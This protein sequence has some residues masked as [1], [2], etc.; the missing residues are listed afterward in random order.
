MS[1]ATVK[2]DTELEIRIDALQSTSKALTGIVANIKEWSFNEKA[3]GENDY[4]ITAVHTA[5]FSFSTSDVY[6]VYY[7][8]NPIA[9]VCREY[10]QTDDKTFG[11]KAIVVYPVLDNEQTDLTKGAVLQLPDKAALIHGGSVCW[12]TQNSSLNYTAGHSKPIEKFYIDNNKNIVFEKP[13]TALS[14]NVSSYT[15]RDLRSGI[16]ETYPIVKIGTQYWMKE[17]LRATCYQNRKPLS[18]IDELGKEAGY[19]KYGNVF[20]YNGEALLDGE[21]AP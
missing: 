9:E 11:S 13:A 3:T 1:S 2:S 4:N 7:Q 18:S 12:D 19:F 17:D 21:L 6:R 5:S 10:L 16:L 14:I 15:I 8:G 20:F